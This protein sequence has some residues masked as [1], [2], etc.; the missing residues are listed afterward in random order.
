[1]SIMVFNHFGI[2]DFVFFLV[3]GTPV[4]ATYAPMFLQIDCK[5]IQNFPIMQTTIYTFRLFCHY[6]H[7]K[8]QFSAILFKVRT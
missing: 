5:I 8:R 4:N 6:L 1:M 7:K 3:L 2:C